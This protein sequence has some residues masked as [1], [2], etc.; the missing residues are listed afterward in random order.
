MKTF[1]EFLKE[2]VD[3][4][5]GGSQNKGDNVELIK[6]FEELKRGDVIYLWNF[7]ENNDIE[8]KEPRTIISTQKTKYTFELEVKYPNGDIKIVSVPMH[9]IK[10]ATHGW[11]SDDVFCAFTTYDIDKDE[12]LAAIKEERGV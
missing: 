8:L 2:S 1:S 7:D 6:T 5:L 9:R 3:F 10:Y 12:L 11:K 4:R